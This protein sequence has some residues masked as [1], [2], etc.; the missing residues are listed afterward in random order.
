MERKIKKYAI[1]NF[2][3]VI[4]IVIC[5]LIQ[6]YIVNEETPIDRRIGALIG[7]FIILPILFIIS[8]LFIII[9]RYYFKNRFKVS[10]FSL[11]FTIPYMIL[12]VFIIFIFGYIIL[13]EVFR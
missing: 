5:K 8:I 12:L 1:L 3:G 6:T 10:L 9:L 11:Y 4:I 2:I 7:G 13:S